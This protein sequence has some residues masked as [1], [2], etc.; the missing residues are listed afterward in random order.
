MSSDLPPWPDEVFAV[1]TLVHGR[2]GRLLT[3]HPYPT[4]SGLDFGCEFP[5]L[6]P[7]TFEEVPRANTRPE[8]MPWAP[9]HYGCRVVELGEDGGEYAVAGH[10]P[11]RRALA[12]VLRYLRVDCGITR[13]EVDRWLDA[14]RIRQRWL[15][16]VT[17]GDLDGEED[18]WVWADDEL[19]E[20][21]TVVEL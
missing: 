1:A 14:P 20:P 3:E 10:V 13:G 6:P 19:R 17:P 8:L 15:V 9:E 16:A 21:V 7:V 2:C 4:A 11:S 12:A 18:G 5:A